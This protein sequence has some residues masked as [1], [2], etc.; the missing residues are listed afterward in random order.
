M[1]NRQKIFNDL[2]QD[3]KKLELYSVKSLS[4]FGSVA[5]GEEKEASDVDI[6]V[7]FGKPIGLFTFM[8][9]KDHLEK[10]LSAPVDLVTEEALHPRL[11]DKIMEGSIHVF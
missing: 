8:A 10:I 11:R 4:L 3:Q 1:M 9:L 7:S 5:R 6:L 2:I